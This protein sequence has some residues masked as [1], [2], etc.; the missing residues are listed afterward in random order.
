MG[1]WPV[2]VSLILLLPVSLFSATIYITPDEEIQAGIDLTVNGDTVLV[3]AGEYTG[4]GNRD[5]D[6]GGRLI[7][8]KSESGPEVTIIDCQADSSKPHRAFQ[9]I[10]GENSSAILEGFTIING[11]APGES[12]NPYWLDTSAAGAIFIKSSSPKINE[13]YFIDNV[14]LEIAAAVLCIQ[15]SSSFTNCKFIRNKAR[16]AGAL[17]IWESE[18][19]INKCFFEDNQGNLIGGASWCMSLFTTKPVKFNNCDFFTNTAEFGGAVSCGDSTAVAFESCTFAGNSAFAGGAI[20]AAYSN[21]VINNCNFR[22]N[23]TLG[24]GYGGAIELEWADPEITGCLFFGNASISTY[25]WH[26]HGG[27]IRCQNSSP[28]ITNCTFGFNLANNGADIYCIYNSEPLIEN[29]ILCFGDSSAAVYCPDTGVVPLFNC[30]DIFGNP[31]G[32]WTEPIAGQEFL[33]GNFSLDPLFCDTTEITFILSDSSPCAPA[34]N[35]CQ[36]IIGAFPVGCTPTDV[37]EEIMLLANNFRLR[38]NYPN[39]FNTTTT[40]EFSLNMHA[41]VEISIFNILGQRVTTIMNQFMPAGSH[42]VN[43]QGTDAVGN[44]VASGIYFY[45]LKTDRY[46]ETRKM[47]FMK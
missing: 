15:S 29:S 38:Q 44:E 34:N 31:F 10:S 16:L 36:V 9:F 32:D 1:K 8:V 11:F 18:I 24:D 12:L 40:I 43:W 46:T 22:G 26:G 13:C 3:A 30:C 35:D 45:R 33:N 7:V 17:A 14:S 27:A 39:P 2:I 42:A 20:Y 25:A 23:S 5:I 19:T 4:E 41:I 37:E 21:P 28:T 6:F 47:M